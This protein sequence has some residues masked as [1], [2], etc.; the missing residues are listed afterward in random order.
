MQQPA[1]N[2]AD[3]NRRRRFRF[4]RLLFPL[5][6]AFVVLSILADRIPA[7]HDVREQLLHPGTYEA[8]KACQAAALEAAEQAAFARIVAEGEVHSTQDALYV[9]GVRVGE[10]GPNGAEVTF[11]FSCYVGPGGNIVNTHKE[12][13]RPPTAN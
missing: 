2:P 3:R 1:P 11:D 9:K 4:G 5:I 10:M 6:L 7:L 13:S 12:P 8:R